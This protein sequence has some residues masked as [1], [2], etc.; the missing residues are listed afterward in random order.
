MFSVEYTS[1]TLTGP[2]AFQ[3]TAE[4]LTT[5]AREI[6]MH[7]NR[8]PPSI[9]ADM[10]EQCGFV[11]QRMPLG[12]GWRLEV[13]RN[14]RRLLDTESGGAKHNFSRNPTAGP[15]I[16]ASAALQCRRARQAAGILSAQPG[17]SL[18]S[19][20]VITGSRALRCP[21]ST[22][23]V[24]HAPFIQRTPFF[25]SRRRCLAKCQSRDDG[26]Q[27]PEQTGHDHCQWASRGRDC[28]LP[29]LPLLFSIKQ[30]ERRGGGAHESRF[31]LCRMNKKELLVDDDSFWCK[32]KIRSNNKFNIPQREIWL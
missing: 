15:A 4:E 19:P 30:A 32:N 11:F 2:C 21:S 31:V 17:S 28:R 10:L 12:T 6:R 23:Q 18:G 20:P 16:L 7:T 26:R 22:R 14:E 5:D 29:S 13:K 3:F 8:P 25:A 27:K 9:A 24:P 1:S